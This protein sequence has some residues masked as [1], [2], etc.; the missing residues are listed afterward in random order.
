MQ[1][2]RSLPVAILISLLLSA[3]AMAQAPGGAGLDETA[4]VLVSRDVTRTIL[5]DAELDMSR[6]PALRA[7][8]PTDLKLAELLLAERSAQ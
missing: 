8:W 6:V 7:D 3:P 2:H 5:Q 1:I 4:R